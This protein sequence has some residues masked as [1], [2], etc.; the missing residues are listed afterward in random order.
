MELTTLNF[1]LLGLAAFAIFAFVYFIMKKNYQDQKDF[2]NEI[3]Q[4]D[5]KPD[6]HSGDKV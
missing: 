5:V 4:K 3:N 6:K 2:E 1:A